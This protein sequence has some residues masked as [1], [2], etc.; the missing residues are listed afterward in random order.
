MRL[1]LRT[2]RLLPLAALTTLAACHITPPAPPA[3]RT[4]MPVVASF[5]RTWDAVI[6]VFAEDGIPIATMDR[7]S[8]LI[9]PAVSARVVGTPERGPLDYADCGKNGSGSPI[10]ANQARFNVV[11]RGD[12][13]QSTV[14]VRAFYQWVSPPLLGE[15]SAIECSTTGRY[16]TRAE[17]AIK[18]RAE[19]TR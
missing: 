6:D 5:G 3:P 16:E 19:A 12:S 4:A 10:V 2:F 18:A 14:Q 8:G 7:A 13:A 15:T 11:V 1:S 17:T 9:V